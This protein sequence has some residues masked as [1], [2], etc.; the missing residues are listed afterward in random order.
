MQ[1]PHLTEKKDETYTRTQCNSKSQ[2]QRGRLHDLKM[3]SANS[4]NRTRQTT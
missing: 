4:K 3:L 1:H 2:H